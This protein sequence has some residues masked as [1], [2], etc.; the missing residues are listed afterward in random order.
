MRI[1]MELQE[2]I[3]KILKS[4]LI[5]NKNLFVKITTYILEIDIEL[6][7]H[8]LLIDPTF[9]LVAQKKRER[10]IERHKEQ[11]D[12]FLQ[13]CVIKEIQYVIGSPT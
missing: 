9:K 11:T 4:L 5:E 1:T 6:C 12:E 3:R 2:W 7:C 10:M 13:V 8:S